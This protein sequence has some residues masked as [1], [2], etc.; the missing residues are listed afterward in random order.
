MSHCAKLKTKDRGGLDAEW[1]MNPCSKGHRDV[2]AA[3]GIA[4]C[5]TCNEMIVRETT[6]EAFD[7]W[8][9]THSRLNGMSGI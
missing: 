6:Q 2:G 8:N 5:Y 9:S 4:H 7:A 1:V 3:G